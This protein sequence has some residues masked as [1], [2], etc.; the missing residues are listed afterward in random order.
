MTTLIPSAELLRWNACVELME[1]ADKAAGVTDPGTVAARAA[2][3]RAS[4]ARA[5]LDHPPLGGRP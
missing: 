5:H 4:A 3:G 2:V 1:E